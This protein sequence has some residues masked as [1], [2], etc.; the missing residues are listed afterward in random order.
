MATNYKIT[1]FAKFIIFILI[2]APLAYIGAS[3]YYGQDPFE[4]IKSL[5]IFNNQNKEMVEKV[6]T[7]PA[8]LPV[9]DT[10]IGFEEIK[11]ELEL[12]NIEIKNLELK[13]EKMQELIDI[14]KK[15]LEKFKKNK[16]N[17]I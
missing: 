4:K 12:K 13:V 14:Q 11:K 3:Y 8:T 17:N 9:K 15:E 1:G 16:S 2:V 10:D 5:E 7:T 6:S